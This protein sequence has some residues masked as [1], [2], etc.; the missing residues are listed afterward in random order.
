[1]ES[2]VSWLAAV[3]LIGNK[4]KRLIITDHA[5]AKKY[6]HCSIEIAIH[7]EDGPKV[8]NMD[9][10]SLFLKDDLEALAIP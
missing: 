10:T 5:G 2:S 8:I 9:V 3:A 1:L 6:L 4:M 7:E